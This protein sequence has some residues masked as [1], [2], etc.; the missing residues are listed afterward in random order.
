[1]SKQGLSARLYASNQTLI[2]VKA[3]LLQGILA[4]SKGGNLAEGGR[5]PGPKHKT[6]HLLETDGRLGAVRLMEALDLRQISF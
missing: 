3:E 5:E 4:A 1:M 2:M 6:A